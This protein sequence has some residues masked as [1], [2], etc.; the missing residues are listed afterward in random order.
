MATPP[1]IDRLIERAAAGDAA[2]QYA[3]GERYAAGDGVEQ[4][5]TAAL[6][7]FRQAAIQGHAAAQWRLGSIMSS[8]G[9]AAA[10]GLQADGA[11]A[12][13]WLEAA[14]RQDHGDAMSLVAYAYELGLGTEVSPATAACW[15]WRLAGRG[16]ADAMHR[17]GT[18]ARNG[19]L[20]PQA[21]H[22]FRAAAER[23]DMLALRYLRE[24][25]GEGVIE[26]AFDATEELRM[27][28]AAA[29]AG[30]PVAIETLG[31]RYAAG[32]RAPRDP[33]RALPLLRRAVA[34]ERAEGRS[35]AAAEALARLE[36]EL[37]PASRN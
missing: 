30:D 18:I 19:S 32:D 31:L 12:L 25:A 14:A 7:L 10:Y 37:A 26:A 4:D 5:R 16:D 11:A 6:H 27:L 3:L 8:M 2:A 22:W 13:R 29:A 33:A 34:E 28:E 36:A 1:G 15:W 21:A 24:L 23:G 9:E 35:G 17:L 20:L